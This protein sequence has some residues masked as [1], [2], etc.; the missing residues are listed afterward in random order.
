MSPK[1]VVDGEALWLSNK[2]T[3]V[4]EQFRAEYANLIP[5]ALANGTFEC[6]PRKIWA[7]VYIYNRPNVTLQSVEEMLKSFELAKMLFCWQDTSGT[8][9][10]YWVGIDTPGRLP[11]GTDQKNGAKGAAVPQE[12]LQSFLSNTISPQ[13]DNNRPLTDEVPNIDQCGF[14]S[15]LGSGKTSLSKANALDGAGASSS[16]RKPKPEPEGFAEFWK[17]YPKKEAKQAALKAWRK[18]GGVNLDAMLAAVEAVK[19][20]EGWQKE[21]GQFIPLAASWLNGR[22]WEDEI[23]PPL[24]PRNGHPALQPAPVPMQPRRRTEV[25]EADRLEYEKHG[26]SL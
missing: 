17:C 3:K 20:T 8:T 16:L 10:G 12:A 11:S 22:R 4:P 9:W 5:L 18:L 6:D 2:L 25:T 26:V 7:R 14:G 24:S 13:P 19:Q 23:T 1:R 21:G 15:G